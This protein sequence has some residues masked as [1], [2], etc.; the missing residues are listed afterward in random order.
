MPSNDDDVKSLME[1]ESGAAS[2]VKASIFCG[3]S[4]LV[5]ANRL[6]IKF[7]KSIDFE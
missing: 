4:G 3:I 1:F 6:G 5:E 2:A 7:S